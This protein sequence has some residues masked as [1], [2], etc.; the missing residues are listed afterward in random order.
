MHIATHKHDCVTL[1]P[2]TVVTFRR[3]RHLRKPQREEYAELGGNFVAVFTLP[4]L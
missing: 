3:R 4:C 1:P 2:T